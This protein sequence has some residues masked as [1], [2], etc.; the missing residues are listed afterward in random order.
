MQPASRSS[1]THSSIHPCFPSSD[2]FIHGRQRMSRG[3]KYWRGDD[4]RGTEIKNKGRVS[5]RGLKEERMDVCRVM[6]RVCGEVRGERWNRRTAD[7]QCDLVLD[8]CI[9][10]ENRLLTCSHTKTHKH[11]HTG[12]MLKG[13]PLCH[14]AAL[15][16][17][18]TPPSSRTLCLCLSVSGLFLASVG[19][20]TADSSS[21]GNQTVVV[22]RTHAG[23]T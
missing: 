23:N 3:G 12:S 20:N 7:R 19:L 5:A 9:S 18:L 6:L 14:C 13:S 8:W 21:G 4:S 10:G 22:L 16:I 1:I 17:I 15:S 2:P 11:T